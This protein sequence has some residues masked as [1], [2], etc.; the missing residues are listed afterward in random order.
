METKIYKTPKCYKKERG[1]Y[2]MNLKKG[3]SLTIWAEQQ[4]IIVPRV[5]NSIKIVSK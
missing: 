5:S 1:T 3:E 4:I 2:S